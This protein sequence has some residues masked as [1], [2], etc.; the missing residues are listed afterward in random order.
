MQW[1]FTNEIQKSNPSLFPSS[2][3]TTKWF[4][5]TKVAAK[6]YRSNSNSRIDSNILVHHLDYKVPN[7]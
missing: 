2:A 4:A 3:T 7:K 5:T 1:F 6:A